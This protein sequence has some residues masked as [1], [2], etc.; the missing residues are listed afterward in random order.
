VI[1]TLENLESLLFLK[2]R[3]AEMQKE[4]FNKRRNAGELITELKIILKK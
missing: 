4:R 1:D 2:I 3:V